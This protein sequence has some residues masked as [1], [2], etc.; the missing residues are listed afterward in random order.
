[1]II[2]AVLSAIVGFLGFSAMEM[3]GSAIAEAGG[4]GAMIAAFIIAVIAGIVGLI[5]GSII[6]HI[7]VVVMGGHGG[8]MQ[9]LKAAVYGLTPYY[10]LGWIP[11][12]RIP[13]RDLGARHRDLR[14]PRA[15]RHDHGPGRHRLADLVGDRDR[16]R[17]D[18]GCGCRPGLP[19]PF[20]YR[21][22]LGTG[23]RVTVSPDPLSFSDNRPDGPTTGNRPPPR[24]R[25]RAPLRRGPPSAPALP[26]PGGRRPIAVEKFN[27]NVSIAGTQC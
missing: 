9:T 19:R 16:H 17:C 22:E 2:N 25:A 18:S 21:L 7:G 5:V 4:I 1:M 10:L 13:C 27:R 15:P 3:P 11:I 24:S 8:F 23:P 26:T 6:L 20:R 14:H 12:I